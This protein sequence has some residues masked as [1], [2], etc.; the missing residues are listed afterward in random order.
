[1]GSDLVG[2]NGAD[3]DMLS[4]LTV[5]LLDM[6]SNLIRESRRPVRARLLGGYELTCIY[7]INMSAT[8]SGSLDE[9]TSN[10]SC[11]VENAFNGSAAFRKMTTLR[12]DKAH[13]LLMQ[14]RTAFPF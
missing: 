5:E 3:L 8:P 7:S 1:V 6:H 10:T 13:V 9:K 2:G 14:Q 4:I 12:A 11:L